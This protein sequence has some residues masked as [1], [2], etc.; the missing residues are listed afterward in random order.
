MVDGIFRRLRPIH[1][2]GLSR[3][4]GKAARRGTGRI[5]AEAAGASELRLMVAAAGDGQ[6]SWRAAPDD[7]GD[8]S[9]QLVG[10][11]RYLWRASSL[12]GDQIEG[13]RQRQSFPGDGAVAPRARN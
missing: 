11:G 10:S 13:Q 4:V 6:N 1:E 5:L 2:H 9:A 3:R 7:S 12:Q 8:V